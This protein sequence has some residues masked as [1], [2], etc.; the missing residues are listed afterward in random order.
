MSNTSFQELNLSNGFLFPAAFVFCNTK[1]L[2]NAEVIPKSC[3]G[4]FLIFA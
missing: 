1:F 4:K 3:R 2:K